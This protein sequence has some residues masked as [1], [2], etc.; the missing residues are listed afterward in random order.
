MPSWDYI[1]NGGSRL[2]RGSDITGYE[3]LMGGKH[4]ELRLSCQEDKNL[5]SSCSQRQQ[6][7]PGDKRFPCQTSKNIILSV[8]FSYELS[9]FQ[10]WI[11]QIG[12]FT[13]SLFS[14]LFASLFISLRQICSTDTN[15][16]HKVQLFRAISVSEAP[17]NPYK[18]MPR[19]IIWGC[20]VLVSFKLFGQL[21]KHKQL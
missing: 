5:S 1:K 10:I 6:M 19:K 3:R 7:V 11:K 18:N 17:L 13:E 14:L 20:H 21:H 12:G 8:T 16:S 2:L 4:G 15:L 9:S